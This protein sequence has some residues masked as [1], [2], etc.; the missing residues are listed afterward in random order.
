MIEALDIKLNGIEYS[1]KEYPD[2]FRVVYSVVFHSNQGDLRHDTSIDSVY[3]RERAKD[4]NFDSEFNNHLRDRLLH[5]G[6]S[7]LILQAKQ[8]TNSLKVDK[9]ADAYRI[10]IKHPDTG[11]VSKAIVL[12]GSVTFKYKDASKNSETTDDIWYVEVTPRWHSND[13]K[14][15]GGGD[16]AYP[17][18]ELETGRLQS[19]ELLDIKAV[20]A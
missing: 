1:K 5:E 16:K 2:E 12:K 6:I 10:T 14:Y 4:G 8:S 9:E 11:E 19:Y 18:G 3:L 17:P 13:Y 15:S 20:Y 7:K